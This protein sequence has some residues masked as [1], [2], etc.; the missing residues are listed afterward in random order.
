MQRINSTFDNHHVRYISST[1]LL[2]LSS[3]F[4]QNNKYTHTNETLAVEIKT[5]NFSLK[6]MG[7]DAYSLASARAHT[8]PERFEYKMSNSM[9]MVVYKLKT[10]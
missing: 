3:F 2:N 7:P 8:L 10:N 5:V 6:K 9:C 4:E 1:T